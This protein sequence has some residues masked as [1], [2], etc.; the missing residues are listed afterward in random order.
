MKKPHLDPEEAKNYRPLANPRFFAKLTEKAAAEQIKEHAIKNDLLDENQSAYRTH[1]STESCLLKTRND[2]LLCL[3]QNEA[4]ITLALDLSAAFDTIDFDLLSYILSERFNIVGKCKEWI[5]SFITDRQQVVTIGNCKS[6][7]M[8][9]K[10]G[11]PQG[12]ILGPLIFMLYLT[13]IGDLLKQM[14][15][16]YQIYADD[17]MIYT[18]FKHTSKIDNSGNAESK[19]E[20]SSR[21]V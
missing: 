21:C 19:C 17:T 11:V 14:R 7:P 13:P 5:I 12:S 15:L 9:L 20:K 4:V 18:S 8:K 1:H 10:Y 6:K 3:D 16:P 2:I